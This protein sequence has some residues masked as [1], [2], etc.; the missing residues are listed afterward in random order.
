VIHGDG[1]CSVRLCYRLD[2]P[3][4]C[5]SLDVAT[6]VPSPLVQMCEQLGRCSIPI[7]LVLSGAIIY[8]YAGQFQWSRAWRVL[9]LAVAVRMVLLPVLILALAHWAG[10][11]ELKQVLLLQAS[12]PA[13]TFPIVMTRLY[14]QDIDTA[15]TV[16]VGTSVLS[17]VTIPLWLV[18]A[19]Q[20]LGLG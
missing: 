14:N 7:A 17:I 10:T 20:F 3:S 16:V 12:M 11:L 18:F 19:A 4:D 2:W 5:G 15:W 1:W 8:D 13:A 9:L 6:W